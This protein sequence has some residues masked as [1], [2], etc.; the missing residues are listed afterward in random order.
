MPTYHAR[1]ITVKLFAAELGGKLSALRERGVIQDENGGL[2]H[3]TFLGTQ[4]DM[5]FFMVWV[6][7]DFLDS[8]RN[9][10]L[11]EQAT[12]GMHFPLCRCL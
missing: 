2:T 11:S 10:D 12:D 1:G 7:A 8:T 9:K 5:P 4:S 6:G 3:I